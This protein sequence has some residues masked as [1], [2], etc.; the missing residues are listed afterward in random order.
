[1]SGNTFARRHRILMA[2]L[3]GAAWLLVA[4]ALRPFLG[5]R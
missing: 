3:V 5:V 4:A 2:V 1:M